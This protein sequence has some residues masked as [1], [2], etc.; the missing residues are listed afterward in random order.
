MSTDNQ[1]ERS[2]SIVPLEKG[3]KRQHFDCSKAPLN[4]F[5][6][7]NA[8]QNATRFHSRTFVICPGDDAQ[9][10]AGYYTL[11]LNEKR[12]DESPRDYRVPI[13]GG[14]PVALL[15]RLAVDYRF[16]GRRLGELLLVDAMR[17]CRL[18]AEQAGCCAIEVVALD[19]RAA[20][21]Y[22]KYGFAIIDDRDPLRLYI[23]MADVLKLLDQG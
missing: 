14:V 10:I 20:G 23:S 16:Q 17:R 6:R 13:D 9:T 1:L 18:V 4:T 11:T 5:L 22:R 3:H 8:R 15:A 12:F 2:Y 21:F 7:E 19:D